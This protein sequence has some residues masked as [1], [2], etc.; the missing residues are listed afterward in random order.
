LEGGKQALY[1][2]ACYNSATN[3]GRYEEEMEAIPVDA[4]NPPIAVSGATTDH[5]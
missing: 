3:L 2:R 4:R 1:E 5:F